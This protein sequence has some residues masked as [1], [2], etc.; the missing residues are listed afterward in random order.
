MNNNLFSKTLKT[1][2]TSVFIS[3]FV[4]GSFYF[5]LSSEPKTEEIKVAEKKTTPKLVMNEKKEETVS[6]SNET[7]KS[8]ESDVL[9]SSTSSGSNALLAQLS[10]E[11]VVPMAPTTPASQVATTTNNTTV[12]APT[13]NLVSTTPT[14]A[15]VPATTMV[16]TRT[17]TGVPATGSESIYLL[18]AAFS[19]ISGFLIV[20][21]KSLAMRNFE[22]I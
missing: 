4:F 19:L 20:N 10:N 11:F 22:R 8:S 15:V 17:A 18:I 16:S 14:S 2:L 5:L 21:G 13:S 1:F 12:T 3:L 6:L 7:Y 9:G